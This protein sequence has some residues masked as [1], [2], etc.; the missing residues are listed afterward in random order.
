MEDL[1]TKDKVNSTELTTTPVDLS[2]PR[3][4]DYRVIKDRQLTAEFH[5]SSHNSSEALATPASPTITPAPAP[6]KFMAEGELVVAHLIDSHYPT[7]SVLCADNRVASMH[8]PLQRLR[9]AHPDTPIFTLPKSQIESL[10][11]FSM[12]R[13]VMAIGQRLAEDD[14]HSVLRRCQPRRPLL[15]LEDICN[16]DNIGAAFRNAAAFG[17]AGILLSPRC[18]DPLYRKALRVS[19]GHILRVPWAYMPSWPD[20][21]EVVKAQG[22]RTLAMTPRGD[23]ELGELARTLQ[24]GRIAILIGSEGPGLTAETMSTASYRTKIQMAPGTD[25]LNAAVASAVAL[26]E[27]ATPG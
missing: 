4:D 8:A 11:G 27:L 22:I 23:A 5:R 15:L 7:L 18:T 13:G 24:H 14:P 9:Q 6:G 26:Y 16:H 21:H 20:W 1:P 17:A 10:V 3:L 19:M 12:H 2:D 25:S